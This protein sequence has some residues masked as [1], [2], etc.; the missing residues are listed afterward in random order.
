MVILPRRFNRATRARGVAL[1]EALIAAI[2]L[3]IALTVLLGLAGQ[4]IRTQA[5]G[6]DVQTATQLADEQLNLVLTRGP[7]DYGKKFQ[8]TGQ[9]DPPFERFKFEL[10]FSTATESVPYTVTCNITWPVTAGTQKVTLSTAM[11]V[12]AGTDPDPDRTPQTTIDRN[13]AP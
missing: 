3:G 12:R 4:A 1:I 11:A 10:A 5:L 8:L 7:D 2:I 6:E 9:C 13:A